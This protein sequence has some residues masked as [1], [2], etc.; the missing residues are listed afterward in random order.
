MLKNFSFGAKLKFLLACA[1]AGFVLVTL[2]AI[3]G[4]NA[5][6]EANDQLRTY[7]DI[8]S[9]VDKISLGI[10][11]AADELRNLNDSNY[12]AYLSQLRDTKAQDLAMLERD[13]QMV[14]REPLIAALKASKTRLEDYAN[15]L[16]SLAEQRSIIGFS[17]QSGYKGE[18]TA[19][20]DQ[21]SESIARIS[22]LNREFVNVR[23]VEGSY[24][25]EPS[26]AALEE[27]NASYERFMS[28]V[29]NFGFA[30]T[31]GTTAQ[32]YY[33]AILAY[34]PAYSALQQAED[35]FDSQKLAF[36]AGQIELAEIIERYVLEAEQAADRQASQSLYTLI[37][38]SI[39]VA[40]FASIL[41]V[42]IS[43]SARRTLNQVITDL[44]KVKEGD[45]TAKATVNKKRHDEFDDLSESLNEMTSGLGNVL[46][47]VVSTTTSVSTMINDLNSAMA[48][49]ADNNRSVTERTNSLAVATDDISNRITTLSSSTEEM[50]EH[51]NETY[52]SAKSGATTIRVVLDNLNETVEAVNKTS[53]QLD[54]LGKLSSNID[55]VIGMIN[56][57][58]EQT[59]LLAL[60]AAIEAARA[61]EAGRGFSVVADEVRSLAE[62]TVD[63]TSKITEIVSTIQTSTQSAINTMEHGQ[64]KLRVIE[65]NGAEAETAM[66]TIET[67][68]QTSSQ[69]S[70]DMVNAIQDVAST[71]VQMSSEMDQIA[72]QLSE[73]SHSI[74]VIVDSAHKIHNMADGLSAKTRVFTL[75]S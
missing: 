66:R 41:M 36:T 25:S 29:N 30:D 4:M 34:G 22:L 54:E 73:D 24:L 2:V 69:A 3:N 13:I 61:G 21:I 6:Q 50:R 52:Q 63:A 38:V 23:K 46:S 65:E 7:G 19:L 18:I 31:V 12:Q 8:G 32:Q 35:N 75:R 53:H 14:D 42:S 72:Q 71:A 48:K 40:V 27:L 58:A 10:L 59:N 60:N 64:Q 56:D 26:P 45:M 51:S 39:A 16:L 20:G 17:S 68:A 33:D 47:D 55:N 9:G 49:I 15:A 11:E 70:N 43:R 5:Q 74:E 1:I 57:L 37:I 67:N 44:V 28:R 62:K